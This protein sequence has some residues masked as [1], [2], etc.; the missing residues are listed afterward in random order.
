MG[1]ESNKISYTLVGWPDWP[2]WPY[3]AQLNARQRKTEGSVFRLSC[4]EQL[5]LAR[6]MPQLRAP[7]P[8]VGHPYHIAVVR[9][10]EEMAP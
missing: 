8:Q 1:L 2:G 10:R 9:L 4:L 6:T 7:L 5:C 3:W